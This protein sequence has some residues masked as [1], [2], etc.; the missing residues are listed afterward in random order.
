MKYKTPFLLLFFTPFGALAE[1]HCPAIS[2]IKQAAQ[3]YTATG[4]GDD[5]WIGV[6]QESIP[7]N[8]A[9][10]KD[11]SEALLIIDNESDKD[12][13]AMQGIFQKCTYNLHDAG[14]QVDMYYGNKTWPVSI[15][16]KPHWAYQ[17]TAFLEIYQCSGVAAEECQFDI[18]ESGTTP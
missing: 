17:K 15:N 2:A 7:E 6:L 4:N 16:G 18:V 9:A 5:E 1:H 3:I 14:R 12:K 13:N 10:I 8:K 11:F